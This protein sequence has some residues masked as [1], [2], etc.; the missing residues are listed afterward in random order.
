MYLALKDKTGKTLAYRNRYIGRFVHN[1]ARVQAAFRLKNLKLSRYIYTVEVQLFAHGKQLFTEKTYLVVSTNP[2]TLVIVPFINIRLPFRFDST[3]TLIDDAPIRYISENQQI[4]GIL[5]SSLKIKAP[6]MLAVSSS[7]LKELPL[8]NHGFKIKTETRVKEIKSTD[9][10]AKTVNKLFDLIRKTVAEKRNNLLLY[11]YGDASSE[12]FIN[13]HLVDELVERISASR[14]AAE[15]QFENPNFIGYVYLPNQGISK[16]TV[17][18][19]SKNGYSIV[20]A[21]NSGNESGLYDNTVVLFIQESPQKIEAKDYLANLLEKHLE[22]SK[23]ETIVIDFSNKDYLFFET[24]IQECR[25]LPFIR[26]QATPPFELLPLDTLKD[27]QPKYSNFENL[28][29][30]FIQSYKKT[31]AM[32]VAFSTSFVVDDEQKKVF[33]E[34]LN[35][36]FMACFNPE[37]EFDL[38]FRLLKEVEEKLKETFQKLKIAGEE[39]NFA[40][41]KA[42][43][44]VTVVNNSGYPIKCILKLE[45]EGIKFKN[46]EKKVVLSA[47]ENVFTIPIELKRSGRIRVLITL[48]TPDGY[49]LA[50]N[51]VYINSNYRTIL[52]SFTVLLLIILAVLIYFRLKLKRRKVENI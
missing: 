49:R 37:Y 17:D 40:S 38:G 10:Q 45:G 43:L 41:P 11:P 36:A 31:K 21:G 26:L 29:P 34:Q 28:I 47:R 9:P 50:S 15:K 48:E 42:E 7:T 2:K 22:S 18:L 4:L 3:G 33:Q 30:S 8:L 23:S 51:V 25:K 39:I 27:Q 44:P 13:N 32:V 35:N 1:E 14:L 19:L 12:I 52:I 24:F 46:S 5:E 16:Q 20:V 6:I